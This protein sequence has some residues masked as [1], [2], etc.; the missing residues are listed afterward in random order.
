MECCTLYSWFH[1][2][3]FCSS[4]DLSLVS[5]SPHG[6]GSSLGDLSKLEFHFPERLHETA[7]CR[8]FLLLSLC[9][10]LNKNVIQILR[11]SPIRASSLLFAERLYE[12]I[13]ISSSITHY[14]Q[15][16][17]NCTQCFLF[18]YHYSIVMNIPPTQTTHFLIT[19]II[20]KSEISFSF[21]LPC[22]WIK[23]K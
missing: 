1:R 4:R 7:T 12:F 15:T 6:L 11:K 20:G 13:L 5:A 10:P 17:R 23:R 3:Y 21:S 16:R 8:I 22:Y 14:L 19:R 18:T 9:M 2:V